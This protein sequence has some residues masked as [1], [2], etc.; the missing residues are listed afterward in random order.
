[1]GQL[2]EHPVCIVVFILDDKMWLASA[3]HDNG[4]FDGPA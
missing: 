1:M 4:V 2:T 3:Q